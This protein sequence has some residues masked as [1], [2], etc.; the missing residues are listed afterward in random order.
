MRKS[1]KEILDA[2]Y[3]AMSKDK[4]RESEAAEWL[5]GLTSNYNPT[6]HVESLIT[7]TGKDKKV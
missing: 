2:G 1:P 5:F 4:G 6:T 3:N 7:G